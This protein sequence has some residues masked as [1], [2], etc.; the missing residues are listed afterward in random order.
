MKKFLGVPW[1]HGTEEKYRVTEPIF[2]SIMGFYQ[3]K[4]E[5]KLWEEI[6]QNA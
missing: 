3:L 5:Q 6:M 4:E 2:C 1:F